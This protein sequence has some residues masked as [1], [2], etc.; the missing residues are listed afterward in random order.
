[1]IKL[2]YVNR[3]WKKFK[4]PTYIDSSLNIILLKVCINNG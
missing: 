4:V 1:M 3:Q 2:Y